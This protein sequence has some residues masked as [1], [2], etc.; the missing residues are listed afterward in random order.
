MQKIKESFMNNYEGFYY[1]NNRKF[2]FLS[3]AVRWIQIKFGLNI[4]TNDI[5]NM[6]DE[7]GFNYENKHV[8]FADNTTKSDRILYIEFEESNETFPVR[9]YIT[10]N[11]SLL[12]FLNIIINDHRTINESKVEDI[13]DMG[14]YLDDE[15]NK[16]LMFHNKVMRDHI[17]A[18]SEYYNFSEEHMKRMMTILRRNSEKSYIRRNVYTEKSSTIQDK[19]FYKYYYKTELV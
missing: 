11:S 6:F 4:S 9:E 7:L 13:I 12:Y 17:M 5:R 2:C 16:V 15:G 1:Q 8:R 3:E 19:V 10:K 18:H 14:I